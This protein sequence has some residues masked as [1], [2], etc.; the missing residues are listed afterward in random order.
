MS[1]SQDEER[2]PDNGNNS[3]S[4]QQNDQEGHSQE[5]PS[6]PSG[7]TGNI[8]H[9]QPTAGEDTVH[10]PLIAGERAAHDPPMSGPSKKQRGEREDMSRLIDNANRANNEKIQIAKHSRAVV[11]T[12]ANDVNDL[13]I[14]AETQ[15]ANLKD[16]ARLVKDIRIHSENQDTIARRNFQQNQ[17]THVEILNCAQA[18]NQLVES[19]NSLLRLQSNFIEKT[20]ALRISLLQL[21]PAILNRM[22]AI[23]T[24]IDEIFG[25]GEHSAAVRAQ[26]RE[27][28]A[29]LNEAAELEERVWEGEEVFEGI[30]TEEEAHKILEELREQGE[31]VTRAEEQQAAEENA[32]PK[33]PPNPE[34]EKH[35]PPGPPPSQTGDSASNSSTVSRWPRAIGGFPVVIRHLR[36]IRDLSA[37]ILA[38]F[39]ISLAGVCAIALSISLTGFWAW[40][41]EYRNKI[42]SEGGQKGGVNWENYEA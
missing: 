41:T 7:H 13:K 8:S 20:E 24:A 4:P 2:M 3:E 31:V 32:A 36:E 35:V 27:Q 42:S 21:L 14:R 10:D 34:R 29:R 33:P 26:A 23:C 9:D 40:G 6:A 1:S 17:A 25:G 12:I 15:E 18:L 38:L 5:A 16:I 28:I 30:D 39:Y 22:G 11:V 37:E 19:N